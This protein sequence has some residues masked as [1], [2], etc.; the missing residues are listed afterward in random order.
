MVL[1]RGIAKHLDQYS[2]FII[3][4][5][6]KRNRPTALINGGQIPPSHPF[7]FEA[8]IATDA[9]GSN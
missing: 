2:G 9:K 8:M 6:R 1:V 5:E 4:A 3:S 7:A